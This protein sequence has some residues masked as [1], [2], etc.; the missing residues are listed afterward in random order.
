MVLSRERQPTGAWR[1]PWLLIVLYGLYEAVVFGLLWASAVGI[2]E[3]A[4]Y[5]TP[6]TVRGLL[7][8]ALIAS[9]VFF[10]V[11]AFFAPLTVYAWHFAL[12]VWMLAFMVGSTWWWDSEFSVLFV[13][14]LPVI[15]PDL[16]LGSSSAQLR[17]WVLW[18]AILVL[19]C[20]ATW[21]TLSSAIDTARF[22]LLKRE[23]LYETGNIGGEKKKKKQVELTPNGY[24]ATE[25]RPQQHYSILDD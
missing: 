19:S 15:P 21:A 24:R 11:S 4:F 23:I 12:P 2:Q 18:K 25:A 14:G 6:S 17:A 9:V 5:N 3:N 22:W 8:G 10:M 13:D 20:A 16:A 1:W 7:L